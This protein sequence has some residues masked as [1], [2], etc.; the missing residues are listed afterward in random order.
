MRLIQL[1][2]EFY[3]HRRSNICLFYI[4]ICFLF[5]NTINLGLFC[6]L[7]PNYTLFYLNFRFSFGLFSALK[8][9]IL[10]KTRQRNRTLSHSFH[11]HTLL[12]AERIFSSATLPRSRR[13]SPFF[14]WVLI[15]IRSIFFLAA[16]FTIS[17]AGR[18]RESRSQPLH[19]RRYIVSGQ[20]P[21]LPRL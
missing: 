11:D 16:N 18:P 13:S 2:R 20:T 19:P 15:T 14:P 5:H 8:S 21:V 9:S 6:F 7:I 4:I 3:T 1:S 17:G 12:G 10:K